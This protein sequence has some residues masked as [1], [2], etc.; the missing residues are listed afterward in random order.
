LARPATVAAPN[1][2]EETHVSQVSSTG[3]ALVIAC[4]ALLISM[5]STA[6]AA[7][8]V[9]LAK[10]ALI[11]DNARKLQGKTPAEVMSA[12]GRVAADIAGK[13]EGPPSTAAGLISIKQGA[14]T[15]SPDQAGDA[16]VTCDN[17]QKA[18]AGGY[19]TAS[20]AVLALDT[21]PVSSGGAWKI[22]LLNPDEDAGA[23]GTLYTVCIR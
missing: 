20:G 17:G 5:G 9:P 2:K 22:R 3:P 21:R 15:L 11:A 6:V 12:A 10:R 23:N 18:I 19:D 1:R 13:A 14:W 16:T 4:L 8:V 7:G